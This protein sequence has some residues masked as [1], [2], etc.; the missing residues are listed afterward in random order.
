MVHKRFGIYSG[1]ANVNSIF[2]EKGGRFF[3]VWQENANGAKTDFELFDLNSKNGSSDLF[4]QAVRSQSKLLRDGYQDVNVVISEATALIIPAALYNP[5]FAEAAL[6]LHFGPSAINYYKHQIQDKMV[7][8]VYPEMLM[9][10]DFLSQAGIVHKYSLML[11]DQ[12]LHKSSMQLQ[13]YTGEFILRLD[14]HGQL[15]LL[16]IF[17]FS[18]PADV[19]YHVLNTLH[20]HNISSD[21]LVIRAV[22]LIDDSSAL[23]NQ[24]NQYLPDFAIV[25]DETQHEIPEF[26]EFPSHYFSSFSYQRL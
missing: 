16:Q 20:L 24:L 26:R 12:P 14:G 2:I 15:L 7:I 11:H 19:V 5:S 17:P 9:R 8:A 25:N 13:F 22:G 21:S 23:Y 3:A 18:T 4:F 6:K 1:K 10:S